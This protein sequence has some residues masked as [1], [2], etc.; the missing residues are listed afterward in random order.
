MKKLIAVLCALLLLCLTAVPA[1]A[2]VDDL[3]ADYFPGGVINA[4][5]AGSVL[6]DSDNDSYTRVSVVI[7]ISSQIYAFGSD[8]ERTGYE[9]FCRKY[10]LEEYSLGF[11]AQIDYSLNSKNNWQY[12]SEWDRDNS[13]GS[14]FIG[15]DEKVQTQ[16]VIAIDSVDSEFFHTLRP[17]VVSGQRSN[18]ASKAYL[19]LIR[20]TLYFR[21]RYCIC[22]TPAGESEQKYLFSDWSDVFG[23]GE[24]VA[25]T[26]DNAPKELPAP[27]IDA[28]A[29]LGDDGNRLTFTLELPQSVYDA[30]LYYNK[31]DGNTGTLQ[32]EL[33]VNGEE[34]VFDVDDGAGKFG[35]A[36]TL[37]LP[38]G[39]TVSGDDKVSLRVRLAN[40][41][42]LGDGPWSDAIDLTDEVVTTDAVPDE[43]GETDEPIAPAPDDDPAP[44]HKSDCKLCGICPFQ[45]LGVCMFVW[46]A[47]ILVLA[48]LI[49]LLVRK[50]KKSK[51]G[52][53]SK[54][55]KKK[56][57]R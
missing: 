15:Y 12:T 50:S 49:A 17:A 57:R 52:K 34:H 41:D 10:D 16:E 3:C 25:T 47:A 33:T 28:L 35:G 21:V 48:L 56:S 32:A 54:Q 1:A 20:N 37:T 2:S 8:Y 53:K 24:K 9:A 39:L 27:V 13:Y 44:K 30:D 19:D 4:P 31:H 55:K 42:P 6:V 5:A 22:Y 23:Y 11:S 46:L 18:G 36:R 38:D 7:P 51:K 43:Q 26:A 45:P 29:L 40:A 14:A